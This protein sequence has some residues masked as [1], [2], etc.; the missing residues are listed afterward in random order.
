MMWNQANQQFGADEASQYTHL[1]VHIFVF[2]AKAHSNSWN[3]SKNNSNDEADKCHVP[4]IV[5]I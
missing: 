5:F 2:S 3:N 4:F 1:Q